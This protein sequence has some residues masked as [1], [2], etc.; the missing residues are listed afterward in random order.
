MRIVRA[1]LSPPHA[2]VLQ[3]ALLL[4]CIALPRP[5]PLRYECVHL[6]WCGLFG[7]HAHTSGT[8]ARCLG[9]RH[10]HSSCVP[11]ILHTKDSNALSR[12]YVLFLLYRQAKSED[13]TFSRALLPSWLRACQKGP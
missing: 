9:I 11:V 1:M 13:S 5:S 10:A 6:A 7:Q 8:Y 2:A 3:K 12:A 4:P